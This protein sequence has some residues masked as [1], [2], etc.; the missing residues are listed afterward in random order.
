MYLW[1]R[2]DSDGT[3]VGFTD[4]GTAYYYAKDAQGDVTGIIDGSCNTVVTYAYDAW[5]KLLSTTGSLASTVG[6]VNPF[7]YRGYYYDSES[8]LYYL[9]SRYYDSQIGRFVSEDGQL[10]PDTGLAGNN[11]FAYCNNRPI[12]GVDYDGTRFT[13]FDDG[14]GRS[15]YVDSTGFMHQG[16]G[17]KPITQS[18]YGSSSKGNSS[19]SSNTAKKYATNVV[20]ASVDRVIEKGISKLPDIEYGFTRIGKGVGVVVRQSK[21]LMGIKL[22]KTTARDIGFVAGSAFIWE[23]LSDASKYQGNDLYKAAAISTVALVLGVGAGLALGGAPIFVSILAGAVIATGV[24]AGETFL[25]KQ[26]IGY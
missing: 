1:S 25:K 17:T 2:Y 9:N 22:L 23:I 10:N 21:E 14:T 13:E 4:N 12:S 3:L 26:W 15:E 8:G 11:L 5:G 18:S 7:L 24:D 16:S 19:K 20:A 6:A